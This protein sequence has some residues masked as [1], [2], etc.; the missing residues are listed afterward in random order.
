MPDLS[1]IEI[2]AELECEM[3]GHSLRIRSNGDR[4]VICLLPDAKT[5]LSLRRVFRRRIRLR[6]LGQNLS[7]IQHTL[8]VHIAGN[9]VARFGHEADGRLLRLLGFGSTELRL[10]QIVSLAVNRS[11]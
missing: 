10:R 8:E 2:N 3:E 9:L 11:S 4:K 6:T 5:L 1:G 7:L